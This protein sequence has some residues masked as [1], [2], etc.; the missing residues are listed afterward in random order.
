LFSGIFRERPARARTRR[1]LTN[2]ENRAFGTMAG[3]LHCQPVMVGRSAYALMIIFAFACSS[4]PPEDIDYPT[5]PDRHPTMPAGSSE[6]GSAMLEGAELDAGPEI[7]IEEPIG[8]DASVGTTI[9]AA[10]G[11]TKGPSSDAGVVL[12]AGASDASSPG[13][14]ASE[15]EPNDLAPNQLPYGK[16]CGAIAAANDTD[17]F[18]FRP[19]QATNVSITATG[20]AV[21]YVGDYAGTFEQQVT[22]GQMLTVGP[23]N[24]AWY[25]IGAGPDVV[26]YSVS[27]ELAP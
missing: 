1:R 3:R 17:R 18:V 14:A 21:F 4:S 27:I 9:D 5:L 16:T 25:I 22:P 11:P 7:P 19:M 15:I 13:C 8:G 6:A 12:E 10:K 24:D 23:S 26:S 20:F 2:D